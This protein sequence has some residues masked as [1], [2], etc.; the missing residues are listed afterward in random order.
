[1]VVKI[2]SSKLAGWTKENHVK[3]KSSDLQTSGLQW[4]MNRHKMTFPLS[5]TDV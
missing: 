4:F 1:M 3:L 5:L 2:L